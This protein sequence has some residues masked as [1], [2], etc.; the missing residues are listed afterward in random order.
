MQFELLNPRKLKVTLSFRDLMAH[1]FSPFVPFMASTNFAFF[2]GNIVAKANE[3]LGFRGEGAISIQV[4]VFHDKEMVVLILTSGEDVDLEDFSDMLVEHLDESQME[5]K[6]D[7]TDYD[8]LANHAFG[9]VVPGEEEY[10]GDGEEEGILEIDLTVEEESSFYNGDDSNQVPNPYVSEGTTSS[11]VLSACPSCGGYNCVSK[12]DF[13]GKP[14]AI[15]FYFTDF[16][17]VITMA[18]SLSH[19]GLSGGSV[20]LVDRHYYFVTPVMEVGGEQFLTAISIM[21]EFGTPA[22]RGFGY[23]LE[24]GKC[25]FNGNAISE[26]MRVFKG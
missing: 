14:Y 25:L 20:F 21:E 7:D 17:H 1:G 11:G 2:L 13:K 6:S 3:E 23:V 12:S 9:D 10:E 15:M 18:R 24:Y 4:G 19:L 26:I 8:K 22:K 5:T 16:E